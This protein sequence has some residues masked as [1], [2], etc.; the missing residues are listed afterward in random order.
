MSDALQSELQARLSALVDPH[1]GQPFAE[2]IRLSLRGDRAA[3]R[4]QLSYP[5]AGWHAALVEMIEGALCHDGQVSAVT[6]EID[7]ELVAHAVQDGL[8]PL[9][10][11]GNVIAVASGKGGVGKSTVAANLALALQAEGARVGVLDADIYGPSQP[12]MLG[13]EGKPQTTPDRRILPMRAHGLQV[14]SIGVLVQVDQA[15]IWRGPM[16]TQALQQMVS[17]TQWSDLDY[18]I[19][20]LPPGTGDIQLTLAQRIPVAGAVTVTTPQDVAV[21]DVRRS[22]AMFNKVRVPVLGLIENMSTHVCSN[23]GHEEAIFGRGG[24]QRMAEEA[25]L[26]LLGEIPLDAGLGRS[27]DTGAPIVAA[28]P[29]HPVAQRFRDIARRVGARLSLQ[30]RNQTIRMPKIRI[31]E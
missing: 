12:R 20:D 17:E 11:V 13:L 5:A 16:A 14:M 10:G 29:E 19:V 3:V 8:S 28:D 26:S 9:P 25:G 18:L 23:C 15:M 2:Q 21:D 6:V 27:T 22:V 30:A 24:G 4:V 1:T 31:V 7:T